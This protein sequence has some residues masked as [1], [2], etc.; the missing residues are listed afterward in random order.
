MFMDGTYTMSDGS[1]SAYPRVLA[2]GTTLNRVG[3]LVTVVLRP[4]G[5]VVKLDTSLAI[6]FAMV[7]S[8]YAGN[9]CGLCGNNNGIGDDDLDVM[10]AVTPPEQLLTPVTRS[11]T[12]QPQP[13][14]T[15][16]SLPGSNGGPSSL[17]H[18][19][20]SNPSGAVLAASM[21]SALNTCPS[22]Q[23]L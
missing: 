22:S 1:S 16:S 9:T 19:C 6:V 13:L 5:V 17:T 21:C 4:S 23:Y 15:I 10:P 3:T 12:P 8:Q 2:D 14:V 20:L 7:P 18:P 11:T